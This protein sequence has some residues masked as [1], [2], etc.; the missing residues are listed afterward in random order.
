MEE[1][2]GPLFKYTDQTKVFLLEEAVNLSKHSL[3]DNKIIQNEGKQPFYRPIYNLKELKLE[4]LKLYIKT[5]LNNRFIW[6][7][8][9]PTDTYIF[10]TKRT[11]GGLQLYVNY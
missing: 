10:F 8:T 3:D 9:F 11:T 4:V 7:S 2:I 5:K 1:N 6:P